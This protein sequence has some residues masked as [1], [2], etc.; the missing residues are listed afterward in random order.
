MT[1]KETKLLNKAY[2]LRSKCL[3]SSIFVDAH[4]G[5]TFFVEYL[6]YLRDSIILNQYAYETEESKMKIASIVAAVAEF[7]AYM[8]AQDSLQKTFHWSNFCELLK[9]NMEDWLN[10]DDSV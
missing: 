9:Q 2:K 7:D 4:A 5:I 8:Q 1:T 6:R 10:I 3:Q